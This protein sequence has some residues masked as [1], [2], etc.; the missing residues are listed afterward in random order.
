MPA[1]N[2]ESLDEN[3]DV[4]TS[5]TVALTPEEQQEITR[6]SES[7]IG[8]WNQLIS[9]TNWEKGEIICQWR[10][11]L[12]DEGAPSSGWS[13]E[14]WSQMVGGVTPQHVGRLRRTFERFGHVY[15][16]FKGI[17][18]SHFYAALD[19]EDAEMWLEGSVQNSWSVSRMRKERWETLG[20]VPE[21]KPKNSDI[22]TV[23]TDEETQSLAIAEPGGRE[24][25]NDK[26][27]PEGP[28]YD[29]GPDFGE[30][31]GPGSGGNSL[32][33]DEPTKSDVSEASGV[34]IRPFE[35]FT[36]LPQDV[37]EA[38]DSFKI[39]IIRHRASEW[40]EFS[41]DEMLGL[42]DALKQLVLAE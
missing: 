26:D 22:V 36:N 39:S 42:L 28:N 4:S 18:W 37:S 5:E 27:I 10:A 8:Q 35:S 13:D 9:T 33:S 32:A 7:Y 11:Q 41:K 23:E 14:H 19:W 2:T 17:Y 3:Q 38:A 16:E 25:G 6:Q 29:E 12:R 21:D 30:E 1:T 34:S 24:K 31:P 40:A 20:K 15:Q